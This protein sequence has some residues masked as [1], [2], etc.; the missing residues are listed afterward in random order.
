MEIEN[1]ITVIT[2]GEK[3]SKIRNEKERKNGG[4]FLFF[5]LRLVSF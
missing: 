2:A 1:L 4:C 3:N 5:S